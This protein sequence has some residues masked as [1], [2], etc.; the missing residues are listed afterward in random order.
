VVA[1]TGPQLAEFDQRDASQII[2]ALGRLTVGLGQP[3]WLGTASPYVS[4]PAPAL[5]PQLSAAPPT[6]DA[7]AIAEYIAASVP[8]HC[9]DGW[10]YL[11]RA[12]SACVAGD[13]T[14][15]L[16]LAYY[17]ELRAAMC[18]LATQAVGVFRSQH[19]VIANG[20]TAL[21]IQNVAT[22]DFAWQALAR[23]AASATVLDAIAPLVVVEGIEVRQWLAQLSPSYDLTAS[24]NE[25]FQVWGFDLQRFGDDQDL[26]NRASYRPSEM[27]VRTRLRANSTS[28]FV[29]E[30]WRLVEPSTAPFGL[31]QAHLLRSAIENASGSLGLT[32]RSKEFKKR[33]RAAVETTLQ[34]RSS[35]A[36]WARFLTRA[37]GGDDHLVVQ[38]AKRATVANATD[39]HLEVLSRASLLLSVATGMARQV[40]STARLGAGPLAFWWR[41]WGLERGLWSAGGVPT[42]MLEMW[43]DIEEALDKLG[44]WEKRNAAAPS[45]FVWRRGVAAELNTLVGYER[46]AL[47]GLL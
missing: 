14:A 35:M 36:T 44:E 30:L 8:L 22:H 3:N 4:D 38:L 34:G 9:A 12:V 43:G 40:L 17:A 19:I 23:W 1:L 21:A 2:S 33:V 28:E 20:P 46:V 7:S 31:F 39:E 47:W 13:P 27:P 25:W 10:S 42:T 41:E 37:Q 11:G 26:R 5:R 24:I 29:K 16:H 18:I 32:P 15:A 45:F 6:V